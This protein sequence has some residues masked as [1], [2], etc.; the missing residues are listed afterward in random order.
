MIQNERYILHTYRSNNV[1]RSND[2]RAS[3][4]SSA[5]GKEAIIQRV[6]QA[7]SILVLHRIRQGGEEAVQYRLLVVGNNLRTSEPFLYIFVCLL[8]VVVV[9]LCVVSL[10]LIT[11]S[12]LSCLSLSHSHSLTDQK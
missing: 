3:S 7:H 2:K 11:A 5:E 1:P 9:V 12:H 4:S 10:S 6:R 8:D